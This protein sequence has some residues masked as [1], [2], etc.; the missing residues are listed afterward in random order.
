MTIDALD[1]YTV[2]ELTR[3]VAGR[4]RHEALCRRGGR[5]HRHRAGRGV[6]AAEDH[7]CRTAGGGR[8]GRA[9]LAVAGGG[10]AE[11]GGRSRRPGGTSGRARSARG[12]GRPPCGPT[13]GSR[14]VASTE[15]RRRD[16]LAVRP[17][18]A[19]GRPG[20]RLHRPGDLRLDRRPGQGGGGATVCGRATLGAGRGRLRSSGR[21]GR[22]AAPSS[23][24]GRRAHRCLL[25]GSGPDRHEPVTRT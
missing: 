23:Y 1:K 5:R 15:Q 9:P 4:L 19:G 8:R 13:G 22:G 14:A 10:K 3:G 18:S 2:V 17:G 25:C 6:D 7:A 20:E 12:R 11:H 24:R 21:V 16:H